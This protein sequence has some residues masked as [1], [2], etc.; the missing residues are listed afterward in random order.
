MSNE[1]DKRIGFNLLFERII[2]DSKISES[3]KGVVR[4]ADIEGSASTL[5][6]LYLSLNTHEP[7]RVRETNC[8]GLTWNIKKLWSLRV[9]RIRELERHWFEQALFKR[10]R[11]NVHR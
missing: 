1:K 3:D 4:S 11:F 10:A 5:L 9:G 6:Y 7:I 2:K 8:H